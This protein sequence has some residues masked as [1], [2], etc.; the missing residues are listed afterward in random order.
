MTVLDMSVQCSQ[1]SIQSDSPMQKKRPRSVNLSSVLTVQLLA[2]VCVYRWISYR[3]LKSNFR[4]RISWSTSAKAVSKCLYKTLKSL[5]QHF[6]SSLTVIYFLYISF[7]CLSGP[8][9]FIFVWV[10]L[11]GSIFFCMS[12]CYLSVVCLLLFN[13]ILVIV[14]ISMDSKVVKW[15]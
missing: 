15:P 11:Y 14:F 7:V 13:S 3:T 10:C 1:F 4:I 2:F 8:L 9:R 6:G 12:Q 5:L